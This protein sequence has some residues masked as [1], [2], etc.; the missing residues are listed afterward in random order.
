MIGVDVGLK[1]IKAVILDKNGDNFSL[2]GIGEIANPVLNGSV[3]KQEEKF[4]GGL[5][6]D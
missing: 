3:L 5:Q 1:S 6:S 4:R 2:V